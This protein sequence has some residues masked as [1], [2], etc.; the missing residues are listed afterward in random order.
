[1]ILVTGATGFLGSE[2]VK[3]LLE[4]GENVKALKRSSSKIP[5]ILLPHT[6]IEW[7]E[8]NINDYFALEEAF[9]GV[10]EVYHCAAYISFDP[11]H[12]KKLKKINI[13]G[14]ENIVNLCLE[15]GIRKLV[16][17]SSIAAVGEAKPGQLISEKEH[18]EFT[19]LQNQYAVSKYQSEME[20][21]RGIAEGLN[22]VIVNPS[23]IIGKNAGAEGSGQIFERMRKGLRFFTLG[24]CGFVDVEDVAKSM[25][26]LMKSNISNERFILNAENLSYRELF[27]VAADHFNLPHPKTAIKPWALSLAWKASGLASIFTGKQ[28]ITKSTAHS[29]SQI[30]EFDNSKIKAAINIEF[31]PISLSIAEIC[32]TLQQ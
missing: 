20:V 26:L 7:F 17:V 27:N 6:N 30:L 14:T 16:H 2:L 22:A 18:W 11:K 12:K 15:K 29:A 10:E 4:K 3:Q 8:A 9:E 25:I 21:W 28:R 32:N 31:K 24:S 19:D 5:V 1:M 13:E 23:I